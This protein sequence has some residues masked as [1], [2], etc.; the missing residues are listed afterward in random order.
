MV[1]IGFV[2]FYGRGGRGGKGGGGVDFFVCIFVN[3]FFL[4]QVTELHLNFSLEGL[5]GILS[6][7]G[8]IFKFFLAFFH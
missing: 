7:E 3:F 5:G 8:H 6:V 4:V 1:L 2:R